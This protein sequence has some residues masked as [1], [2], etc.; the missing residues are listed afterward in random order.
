MSST[1]S[2]PPVP[3]PNVVADAQ[4]K[5]NISAQQGSNA[6]QVNPFGN[7]SYSYTKDPTTGATIPTATCRQRRRWRTGILLGSSAINWGSPAVSSRWWA[8]TG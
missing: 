1:P 6:N 8:P 3:D 4:Q 7:L 2:P 5:Y